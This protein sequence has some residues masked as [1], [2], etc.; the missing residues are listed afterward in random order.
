MIKIFSKDESMDELQKKIDNREPVSVLINEIENIDTH[1]NPL[2][3]INILFSIAESLLQKILHNSKPCGKNINLYQRKNRD[4]II[5]IQK[6]KKA[7]TIRHETSHASLIR[8]IIKT[9]FT[10]KTYI[11]SYLSTQPLKIH[12]Q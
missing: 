3:S 1:E 7:I 6:I 5:N 9:D 2:E 11:K 10:I 4:T 12:S 8:D